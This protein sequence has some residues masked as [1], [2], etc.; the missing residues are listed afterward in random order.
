VALV[1]VYDGFAG[2]STV[3]RRGGDA[4][5]VLVVDAMYVGYGAYRA[6]K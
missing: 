1:G 4:S 6:H 5:D 2:H 3:V